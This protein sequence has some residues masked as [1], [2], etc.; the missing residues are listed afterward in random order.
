MTLPGYLLL[1]FDAVLVVLMSGLAFGSVL[2]IAC[3]GKDGGERYTP[4]HP[5]ELQHAVADLPAMR[6]AFQWDMYA[7]T[8]LSAEHYA[9]RYTSS[10]KWNYCKPG[11]Q[12]LDE[13][14]VHCWV[15]GGSDNIGGGLNS[16]TPGAF[17]SSS[18]G[19]NSVIVRLVTMG[20]DT[21]ASQ[22]RYIGDG[23]DASYD[24]ATMQADIS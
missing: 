8:P 6:R 24:L 12:I 15:P 4:T 18:P 1:L 7:T 2:L 22:N 19:A 20:M 21:N 13:N 14:S 9:A 11:H 17:Y 5:D 23:W 10:R 16:R 3:A